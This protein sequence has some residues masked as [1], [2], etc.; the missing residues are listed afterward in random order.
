[1]TPYKQGFYSAINAHLLR[2][3]TEPTKHLCVSE[4]ERCVRIICAL[5][6]V[7][8]IITREAFLLLI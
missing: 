3:C 4:W 1:M 8:D 2:R 7:L 5:A 6:H